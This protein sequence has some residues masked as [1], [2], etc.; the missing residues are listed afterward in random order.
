MHCPPNFPWKMEGLAGYLC[1]CSSQVPNEWTQTAICN[2]AIFL[3]SHS[4]VLTL[5]TV[6]RSMVFLAGV[7]LWRGWFLGLWET[8]IE[9]SYSVLISSVQ[10]SLSV[11]SNSLWPHGLKHTRL[12]C[13]STTPGVFS[14]PVSQWCY[15]NIS[16][17]VI[18]FSFCI[19]SFPVAGSFLMS[20]FFTSGGQSTGYSASASVLP[21]N[22][23]DWFPIGSTGLISLLSKGL[24]RVFSDTTV[25]KHQFLGAQLSLWSNSQI[26]TGLLENHSFD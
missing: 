23:Q 24:W 14:C 13:T 12:H 21:T 3:I 26:H 19:Q 8:I 4:S 15:P 1:P 5:Q 22:I 20:Q 16:F 25:Q 9:F 7:V 10:F 18:P 11:M 17:S 2:P 6:M